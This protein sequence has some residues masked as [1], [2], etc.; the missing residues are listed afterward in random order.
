MI[1]W[2]KLGAFTDKKCCTN[3]AIGSEIIENIVGKGETDGCHHCLF[4]LNMFYKGFPVR[5]VKNQKIVG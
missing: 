4:F 1:D 5:V 2:S 3:D